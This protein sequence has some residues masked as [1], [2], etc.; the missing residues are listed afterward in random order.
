M[1][2]EL[3]FLLLLI[4]FNAF[5]AASEIALI[6]LNDNKIKMMAEEG[7]KKARLLT[8]LLNEPGRFLATIQVG[9]TLAG[10]LASA[11]AAKNFAE[12]LINLLIAAR[13][14]VSETWLEGIS[15]ISITLV[16][17]YFSL[18]LGELVLKD[19]P[20]RMPNVSP[21]RWPG[22]SIHCRLLPT[23]L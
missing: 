4:L 5:F 10:F 13:V 18:V 8:R 15:V 1:F 9:V 6:S 16:L 12:P 2:A 7:H 20:C 17:S 22:R 3:L 11:F 23:L 19:W 21:C 14:P